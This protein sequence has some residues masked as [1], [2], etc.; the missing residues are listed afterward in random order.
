MNR[1]RISLILALLLLLSGC[2]RDTPHTDGTGPGRMVRRIE[3]AIHPEDPDFARTYVTQENMN[4]LLTLLRSMENDERPET[5]PDIDG[6]QSLYTATVTFSNGQ[7]NIYYLLG[8]TYLRLG[9]NDWCVIDTDLSRKFTDFIGN[10]PSDD[11][12]P[13]P[14]TTAAPTETPAPS[15]TTTE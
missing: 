1:K 6:G 15:E 2:G 14:E 7:Q 9:D 3:V 11:G 13:V 10:H 4:E 8:H 5:E 12:T